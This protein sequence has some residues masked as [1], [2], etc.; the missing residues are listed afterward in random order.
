MLQR[1]AG[2]T[3]D[4]RM[5]DSEADTHKRD[6]FFQK[7]LTKSA[8]GFKRASVYVPPIRVLFVFYTFF[9]YFLWI[10]VRPIL[11]KHFIHLGRESTP[12]SRLKTQGRMEPIWKRVCYN[13][14]NRSAI[15]RRMAFIATPA[16]FSFLAAL[17]RAWGEETALVALLQQQ[18]VTQQM[19]VCFSVVTDMKHVVFSARDSKTSK[20][21]LC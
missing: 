3:N 14:C 11:G 4:W 9:K 10:S 5:R 12:A 2:R 16:C 18:T 20:T 15:L 7:P 21:N 17:Q 1:T 8:Q 6:L 19:V 13:W